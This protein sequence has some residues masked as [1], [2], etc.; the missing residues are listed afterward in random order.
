MGNAA[1]C[2]ALLS[3]RDVH[4]LDSKLSKLQWPDLQPDIY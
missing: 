2:M 1:D 4:V 3:G